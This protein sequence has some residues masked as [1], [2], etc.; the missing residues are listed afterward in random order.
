MT[1]MIML[2]SCMVLIGTVSCHIFHRAVDGCQR[3]NSILP[4]QSDI[5]ECFADKLLHRRH[6]YSWTS[7][8]GFVGMDDGGRTIISA[9]RRLCCRATGLHRADPHVVLTS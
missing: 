4:M 7:I 8:H 3:K 9:S 2:K 5:P 6:Q 1:D